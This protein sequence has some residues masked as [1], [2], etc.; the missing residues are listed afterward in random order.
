MPKTFILMGLN[1]SPCEPSFGTVVRDIDEQLLAL[2][3]RRLSAACQLI[4]HNVAAPLRPTLPGQD[5]AGF[6]MNTFMQ[7]SMIARLVLRCNR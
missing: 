2:E 1:R 6:L 5:W 3:K 7:H 4:D